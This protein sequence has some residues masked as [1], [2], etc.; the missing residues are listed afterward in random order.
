[1]T[2][3]IS[4]ALGVA[5]A[6]PSFLNLTTQV[7]GQLAIQF[8]PFPIHK[9]INV[10][11]SGG[12]TCLLAWYG[13]WRSRREERAYLIATLIAAACLLGGAVVFFLPEGN[14]HNLFNAAIVFL[15]VPAAGMIIPNY[16]GSVR[17]T[18]PNAWGT[19]GLFI[20]YLPATVFIV[21]T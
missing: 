7:K 5:I 18:H 2:V 16:N 10:A 4:L 8:I 6:L 9:S 17:N 3:L 21:S 14:E 12:V 15:S 11:L 20:L 19:A 13:F 1:L